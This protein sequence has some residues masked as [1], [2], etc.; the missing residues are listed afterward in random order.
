MLAAVPGGEKDPVH[1]RHYAGATLNRSG[2][3]QHRAKYPSTV[4][5]KPP[6]SL[7]HTSTP[8]S[9]D[10]RRESRNQRLEYRGEIALRDRQ[11]RPPHP[12]TGA[13]EWVAGITLM[14]PKARSATGIRH[15]RFQCHQG[16]GLGPRPAPW[17]PWVTT[18]VDLGKPCTS[19]CKINGRGDPRTTPPTALSSSFRTF[20]LAS[21]FMTLKPATSLHRHADQAQQ[22]GDD[23][24]GSRPDD[25]SR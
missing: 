25:A 12:K 3:R 20:C 19:T 13:L 2:R 7:S 17:R 10:P 1:R 9:F 6:N 22:S 23:G 8:R 21:T 11:D 4:S 16:K 18:D 14:Q 15:G 24:N 5:S